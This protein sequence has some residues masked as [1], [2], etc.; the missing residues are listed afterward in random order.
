MTSYITAATKYIFHLYSKKK[1]KQSKHMLLRGKIIGCEVTLNLIILARDNLSIDR[2]HSL[3]KVSENFFNSKC[4]YLCQ[5][6]QTTVHIYIRIQF[7]SYYSS[8]N[9]GKS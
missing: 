5:G 8:I 2:E 4:R 6:N 9:T 3:H 1:D 7:N